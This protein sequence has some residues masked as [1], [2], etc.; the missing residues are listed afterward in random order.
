[1]LILLF[2]VY[3]RMRI[4]M[5]GAV[6]VGLHPGGWR[7]G[8]IPWINWQ[9][10]WSARSRLLAKI[11][12]IDVPKILG[13]PIFLTWIHRLNKFSNHRVLSP[14]V[15]AKWNH[16]R[17]FFFRD[18]WLFFYITQ[19]NQR[20]TKKRNCFVPKVLWKKE[21]FVCKSDSPFHQSEQSSYFDCSIGSNHFRKASGWTCT[22]L[23]LKW[24][25]DSVEVA[26]KFWLYISNRFAINAR[27]SQWSSRVT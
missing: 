3:M 24:L 16:H 15:F 5:V 4:L 19:K 27:S 8:K 10:Y 7:S 25:R 23:V 2:P 14:V 21:P 9:R 22:M 17:S 18:N 1:M 13:L 26:S 12:S 20:K 6:G 11:I